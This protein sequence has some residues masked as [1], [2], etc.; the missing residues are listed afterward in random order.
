MMP[1]EK[2]FLPNLYS[3]TTKL[4]IND[5]SS[6]SMLPSNLSGLASMAGISVGGGIMS[7]GSKTEK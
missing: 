6:G 1:P 7:P 5:D 2:S 3:S 4:L